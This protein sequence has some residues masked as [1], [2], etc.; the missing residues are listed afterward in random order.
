MNTDPSALKL[1]R[2]SSVRYDGD[3]CGGCD[4]VD[5][6]GTLFVSFIA[7]D[8]VNPVFSNDLQRFFLNAYVVSLH[9]SANIFRRDF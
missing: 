9:L 1:L 8:F 5:F 3:F 4:S 6:R 2:Y 7:I